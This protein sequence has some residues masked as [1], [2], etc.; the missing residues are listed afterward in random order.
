MLRYQLYECNEHEIMIEKE[1]DYIKNYVELQR[2]RLDENYWVSYN[3]HDV[4]NC[5]VAPLLL[6]PFVENAFKHVSHFPQDNEI[7]IDLSRRDKTLRMF[8]Y[9]TCD[10]DYSDTVN[11]HGIG[12]KN[13]RR[14]LALLYPNHHSLEIER[15]P[16]SF[17]VNLEIT[18]P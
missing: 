3:D 11:G 16:N 10:P 1:V 12:L 18:M 6:I 5:K 9:N 2:L 7:R 4:G 14:R 17:K 8:V 13:V 15:K